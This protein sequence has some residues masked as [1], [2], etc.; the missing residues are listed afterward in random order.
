MVAHRDRLG[1]P[2]RR[3]ATGI[4]I[5][6]SGSNHKRHTFVD[7]TAIMVRQDGPDDFAAYAGKKMGVRSNTTTKVALENTL[8]AAGMQVE[9]F[10]FASH[11]DGVKALETMEID[12][13]FADQSILASLRLTSPE[14][15]KLKMSNEI[16]TIE[17]HG[18]AMARGDADFR[19]LVDAA[20]SRMYARGSMQKVFQELLPGVQPGQG[21]RA[22]YVI[23]PILD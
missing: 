14:A 5:V 22:M 17:K 1:Y 12:A 13:Y 7:G 6:V 23:A 18:L 21:L 16:L 9:V 8:E 19:L 11:L 3:T 2:V 20:L 4:G 15:A 10:S